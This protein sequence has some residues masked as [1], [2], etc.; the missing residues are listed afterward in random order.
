MRKTISS[1]FAAIAAIGFAGGAMGEEV[2]NTVVVPYADLDL[3]TPAG[4]ATLEARI[5]AAAEDV[6]EKPFIRDLNAMRDYMACKASAR[7]SALE[8]VSLGNPYEGMNLAS[9]F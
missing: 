5:N 6:C 7:A 1:V 4:S 2:K 8:Q 3:A 9:I